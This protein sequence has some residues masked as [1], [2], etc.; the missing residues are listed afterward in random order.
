MRLN[1]EALD[2]EALAKIKYLVINKLTEVV[3]YYVILSYRTS[4]HS[5]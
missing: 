5:C 3:N 1:G 2:S 4:S